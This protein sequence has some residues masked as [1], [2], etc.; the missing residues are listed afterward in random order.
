[1]AQ[2]TIKAEEAESSRVQASEGNA[3]AYDE[4]YHDTRYHESEGEFRPSGAS[5]IGQSSQALQESHQ[6]AT[7]LPLVSD[8]I[9]PPHSQTSSAI[10]PNN[11]V[12]ATG[13][14][15][16]YLDKDLIFPGPPP[17]NALYS[18]DYVLQ[19]QG[20]KLTLRRSI[21]GAARSDGTLKKVQDKE[22]YELKRGF[23]LEK[24]ELVG[25]RRSTYKGEIILKL[26]TSL[27]GKKS[28]ECTLK[29]K[30]RDE[31]LLRSQGMEWQN[32]DGKI[33]ARERDDI[34]VPS[35]HMKGKGKEKVDEGRGSSSQDELMLVDRSNEM[36][37]DLLVAVWIAKLWYAETYEFKT[38]PLTLDDGEL[39]FFCIS[40][41][42]VT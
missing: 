39:H 5:T 6:G 16:L 23:V 8:R 14:I 42:H 31:I 9:L 2:P 41:I 22:L 34:V 29:T 21:P 18:L 11:E 20:G 19:S 12:P 26:K 3:P 24:F 32:A 4:H 33:I 15:T 17:C 7:L 27:L 1:M 38:K 36:L 37:V 35:K 40:P 28:W 30:S 25:Q 13:P 10:S